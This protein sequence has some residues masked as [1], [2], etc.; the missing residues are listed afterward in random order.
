VTKCKV[1]SITLASGYRTSGRWVA[2]LCEKLFEP[3]NQGVFARML[4]QQAVDVLVP[5][6]F[7]ARRRVQPLGSASAR[8]AHGDSTVPSRAR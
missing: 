4:Q 2:L 5:V 1:G 6:V 8:R 3:R 7:C